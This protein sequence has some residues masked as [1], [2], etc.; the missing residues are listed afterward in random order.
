M[1]CAGRQDEHVACRDFD[2]KTTIPAENQRRPPYSYAKRLMR[3]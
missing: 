1:P 2:L 3:V